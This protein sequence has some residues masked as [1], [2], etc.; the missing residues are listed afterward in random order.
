MKKS[1]S[2]PKIEKVLKQ[3]E[4][5]TID[6]NTINFGG[7]NVFVEKEIV[8]IKKPVEIKQ[9]TYCKFGKGLQNYNWG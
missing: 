8:E 5:K 9:N 1:L 7:I 2:R 6:S 4:K 3:T